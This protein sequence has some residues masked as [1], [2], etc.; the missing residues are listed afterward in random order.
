[1]QA[2]SLDAEGLDHAGKRSCPKDSDAG[3][4]RLPSRA[5][6]NERRRRVADASTELV[7]N[8]DLCRSAG[9]PSS[10]L[11]QLRP[12]RSIDLP[13][14]RAARTLWQSRPGGPVAFLSRQARSASSSAY[15]RR[16]VGRSPGDREKRGLLAA[17]HG[18]DQAWRR[19]GARNRGAQSGRGGGSGS[20]SLNRRTDERGWGGPGKPRSA[21]GDVVF[22]YGKLAKAK[23]LAPAGLEHKSNYFASCGPHGSS[24]HADSS[25]TLRPGMLSTGAL[26]ERVGRDVLD[27]LGKTTLIWASG[28][29][30]PV[31]G[32]SPKG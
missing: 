30:A 17:R 7:F 10:L 8:T 6:S 31:N 3:R 27:V 2:V 29:L 5:G 13:F 28:S 1:V 18:A 11:R 26:A 14:G 16:V 23:G 25:A 21:K 15:G 12:N 22:V 4:R 24:Y 19:W 20:P 9:W 32:G